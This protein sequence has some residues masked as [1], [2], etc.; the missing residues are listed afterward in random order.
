M[1]LTVVSPLHIGSGNELTVIDIVPVTEKTLAVLDKEKLFEEL[2][3]RGA[4]VEELLSELRNCQQLGDEYIWR[5][6]L[7]KYNV[8]IEEVLKYTLPVVGGIGSRS[9]R[10]REFI[11]TNGKPYIPGSSVKGAIRTAI[12]YYV[13]LNNQ[14]ELD[15]F[16]KY[17]TGRDTRVSREQADDELEKL[18]F[19]HSKGRYEPK[20]D[21]MR[22]LIV[23][24]T[25]P[26][27]LRH[28][29]MFSVTTVGGEKGIPQYVEGIEE[30]TLDVDIHVDGDILREGLNNKA[31]NGLLANEISNKESFE[32]LI[33]TAIDKFSKEIVSYETSSKEIMKYGG[34][35]DSVRRFYSKL[36]GIEG[37]KLR[38]G[39]GSGWYS[40]TIGSLF[41]GTFFFDQIR[42][43]FKLGMNPRTKKLSKDFPKTRRVAN[44]KPMGW[45]VLNE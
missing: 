27:G 7:G 44:G 35:K 31:F 16:L 36:S 45:V 22:A 9:V 32:N 25:E 2:I 29:K 40:M 28:L 30:I 20:N 12:F 33:W 37:H 34:F 8:P 6:Y 18:I 4:D 24:D 38:V 21:P 23:R 10:I 3:K 26:F 5:M 11:K 19:G 41:I 43:K 15:G 14:R 1:K 13:A 39:W 17:L 42:K